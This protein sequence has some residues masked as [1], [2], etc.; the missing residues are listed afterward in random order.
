MEG[1][2]RKASERAEVFGIGEEVASVVSKVVIKA[3]DEVVS[4]VEE[5]F[6]KEE[7]IE[8]AEEKA[9]AEKNAAEYKSLVGAR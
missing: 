8:P 5:E 3:E 1:V 6:G 2:E 7:F 4:K 9:A